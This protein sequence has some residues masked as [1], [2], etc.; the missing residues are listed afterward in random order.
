MKRALIA[1]LGLGSLA[2]VRASRAPV[3][4]QPEPASV[5]A[6]VAP[7][8]RLR[9]KLLRV[10]RGDT[11]AGLLRELGAPPAALEVAGALTHLPVD[12]EVRADYLLD[13][14]TPQRVRVEVEPTRRVLLEADGPRWTVREEPVAWEV[15]RRAFRF[16]VRP[17][18]W[19]A[20]QDAGLSPAQI[21][22][23]GRLFEF[24]LDFN[25][26]LR[27]GA[28][29]VV[30][31][32]QLS[33]EGESGRPGEI[34]AAALDNGGQ[35]LVALRWRAADGESGWYAPDGQPRKR[36]FLRSPLEFSQ[37]TSSFSLRRYH[38]LLDLARPH[39][40][41]DLGAPEGTPVRAVA[42]GVVTR[43]GRNGGHGNQVALSHQAPW[44]TSYSHLS[45]IDVRA[46]QT[47]RQGQVIGAVGRTGLATGPHLHY[48]LSIGGRA[49]DPMTVELPRASA[50][51]PADAD[52]TPT[53][54]ALMALLDPDW[55][56]DGA[57]ELS[58]G[59]AAGE[60]LSARD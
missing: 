50:I 53:R 4:E 26:E 39:W 51:G 38:P 48:E 6:A 21:L 3:I 5:V 33:R 47:V 43:A 9:T 28:R 57:C 30:V 37:V 49:V 29:L 15:G 16:E 7:S 17:S 24:D 25:T 58:S 52:F 14:A 35:H 31:T 2:A 44:A 34:E 41:V 8:P 45:R 42:D 36:P 40:G 60:P 12:A 18:L 55:S 19:E 59:R 20:A 23:V 22:A 54:D 27:P 13:E 10:E 1:V 11:A 46:G 32:E 56:A